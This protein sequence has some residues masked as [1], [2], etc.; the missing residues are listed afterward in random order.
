MALID[1]TYIVTDSAD[2]S[3]LEGVNIWASSDI[4]GQTV[5][6][7][8]TTDENGEVVLSLEEDEDVYI[9]HSLNG[10]TFTNPNFQ[11]VTSGVDGTGEG[12][13][14]VAPVPDEIAIDT[15][16]LDLL[17]DSF[18]EIGLLAMDET[19]DDSDA[20]YGLRR[21]N[22]MID[23][24][25]LERL[26]AY[27]VAIDRYTLTADQ[28]THTIGP[29]GDFVAERPTR[30]V[31]ANLVITDT[32][33]ESHL[34]ISIIESAKEWGMLTVTDQTSNYCD[35][36]YCDYA[37]PDATIY[38]YPY[39]TDA[40]DLELFTWKQLSKF[41]ALTQNVLLPPGYYEAM[42]LTLAEKLCSSYGVPMET[43]RTVSMDAAMA[44]SKVKSHNSIA[45]LISS[46]GCGVPTV[47]AP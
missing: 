38:L 43:R 45:P 41:V 1:W 46:I 37:Y 25:K 17:S 28:A 2:D 44:R 10:Y 16:V 18:R 14:I 13:A 35:Y 12:T 5:L 36:L 32:D 21:L 20:Q 7:T 11:T 34:P 6:D 22:K 29:S 42:M 9:W 19:L 27:Q 8:G 33:P 31:K 3:L 24:W 39:L 47:E 15:S 4:G 26:I 23:S 30:I 40:Y